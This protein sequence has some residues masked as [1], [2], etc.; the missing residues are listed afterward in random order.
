MYVQKLFSSL[1][2]LGMSELNL[3]ANLWKDEMKRF[4]W[5]PQKGT[6]HTHLCHYLNKSHEIWTER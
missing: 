4:D 5:T 2:V 6:R 1:D 3:S